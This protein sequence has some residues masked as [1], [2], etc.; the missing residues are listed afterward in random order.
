MLILKNSANKNY[1]ALIY[2]CLQIRK[3]VTKKLHFAKRLLKR[4]ITAVLTVL[5]HRF[6]F[7]KCINF[8]TTMCY[9]Q[10]AVRNSREFNKRAIGALRSLGAL[11]SKAADKNPRGGTPA[12]GAVERGAPRHPRVGRPAVP[13]LTTPSGVFLPPLC[14][15]PLNV[16]KGLKVLRGLRVLR[17]DSGMAAALRLKD[18]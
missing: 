14:G 1:Y 12:R 7:V 4:P 13:Q 9:T 10:V 3:F 18:A 16:Y 11:G 15:D 5:N 17:V 6:D 2:S 8:V